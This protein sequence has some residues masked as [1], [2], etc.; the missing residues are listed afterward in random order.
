MRG[1]LAEIFFATGYGLPAV[2]LLIELGSVMAAVA[3]LFLPAEKAG[4]SPAGGR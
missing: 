3:L 4:G 2:A 1:Q